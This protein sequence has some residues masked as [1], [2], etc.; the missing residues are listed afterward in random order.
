MSESGDSLHFPINI[1]ASA[2]AY[3]QGLIVSVSVRPPTRQSHP[4]TGQGYRTKHSG[5]V[6]VPEAVALT[7]FQEGSN[8][9]SPTFV[10][11]GPGDHE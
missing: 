8:G 9:M 2:A 5:R 1:R 4:V 3:A 11:L 10:A 6:L 7:A